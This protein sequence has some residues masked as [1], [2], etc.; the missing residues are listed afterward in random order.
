MNALDLG[1]VM[2]LE[3][4]FVKIQKWYR[5]TVTL[6]LRQFF[7]EKVSKSIYLKFLFKDCVY[8]TVHHI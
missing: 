5:K 7:R 6:R 1:L 4:W 8:S 3:K 2:T